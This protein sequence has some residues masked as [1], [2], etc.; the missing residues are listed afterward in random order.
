MPKAEPLT[1]ETLTTPQAIPRAATP[2][3][4]PAIPKAALPD[5]KADQVPLQVR[6]PREE[7]RAIKIAA[8]ER[9]LTISDFMRACFHAYMRTCTPKS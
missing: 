9:D 5:A 4:T 1:L 8:A 2:A 7:A 3:R 6:I